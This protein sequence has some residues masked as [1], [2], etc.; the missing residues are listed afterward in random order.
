MSN[1]NDTLAAAARA[2][3]DQAEREA[4]RLRD[5]QAAH[6]DQSIARQDQDRATMARA[7][8]GLDRLFGA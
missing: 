6:R 1:R 5:A 2:A 4:Q 3:V 7:R 8:A